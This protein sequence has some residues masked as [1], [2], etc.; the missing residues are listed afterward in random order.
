MRFVD[1]ASVFD[2]VDGDFLR[3]IM[4]ADG[5][6]QKLLG[7]IKA[8][9]SSTKMKVRA[10][11]SDSMPFEIRSAVQQGC[12]LSPTPIIYIIDWSLG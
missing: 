6:P 8:Y 5:M 10:S 1:F 4:A 3:Q 2:P 12:A 11:G 7:L 9:C